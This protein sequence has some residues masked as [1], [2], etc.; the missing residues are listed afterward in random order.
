MYEEQL[1]EGL[2]LQ[3]DVPLPRPF[4]RGGTHSLEESYCELFARDRFQIIR[5]PNCKIGFPGGILK[6]VF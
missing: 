1:L 6:G 5:A 2:Q 4:F 3:R